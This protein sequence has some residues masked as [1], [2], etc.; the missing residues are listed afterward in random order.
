MCFTSNPG[1]YCIRP[2]L[3]HPV[4]TCMPFS[5]PQNALISIDAFV[6]ITKPHLIP[7]QSCDCSYLT[8]ILNWGLPNQKSLFWPCESQKATSSLRD[9]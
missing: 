8:V 2:I 4:L 6:Y 5:Q 7:L 3:I 1:L 9:S